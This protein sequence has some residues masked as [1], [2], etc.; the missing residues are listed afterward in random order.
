MCQ[1]C[2]HNIA[3]EPPPQ[4]MARAERLVGPIVIVL[5]AWL[6]SS[7]HLID[8]DRALRPLTC[9]LIACEIEVKV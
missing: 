8:A 1:F 3:Y 9:K 5:V 7:P 2:I 4:Y 6:E